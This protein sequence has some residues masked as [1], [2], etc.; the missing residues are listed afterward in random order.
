[1]AK[2]IKRAGIVFFVL[3]LSLLLAVGAMCVTDVVEKNSNSI[4]NTNSQNN[5]LV[6]ENNESVGGEKG[7]LSLPSNSTSYEIPKSEYVFE[8][9]GTSAQMA[10][11]W[12]KATQKSL[13]TGKNVKVILM[14][15]W[16]A[17]ANSTYTTSFG[18]TNAFNVGRISVNVGVEITLDLNGNTI[19]RNLVKFKDDGS[20][21]S[22]QDA[23]KGNVIFVAGKL[24][25]M[26]SKY[27]AVAVSDL[28]NQYKGVENDLRRVFNNLEYGK[29]TGGAINESSVG[30]G[31]GIFT[32]GELN[33]YSGIIAQNYAYA[34]GAIGIVTDATCNIYGGM[35]FNNRAYANGGIGWEDGNLS[36]YGGI[37]SFNEDEVYYADTALNRQG[38]GIWY[39]N[40]SGK[41]SISNAIIVY[42]N[43]KSR[44]AGVIVTT[45]HS[46]TISSTDISYNTSGKYGAGIYILNTRFADM[47]NSTISYNNANSNAAGIFLNRDILANFDGLNIHH[48]VCTDG[49]GAVYSYS[50]INFKNT[51]IA[52]NQGT[53]IGGLQFTTNPAIGNVITLKGPG[54]QIYG[55]T[56]QDGAESDV[57]LDKGQF[58]SVYTSLSTSSL[59]S[60]IG[61]EL[62]ATYGDVPFTTGYSVT[63]NKTSAK[64]YFFANDSTKK[65]AEVNDEVSLTASTSTLSEIP[66]HWTS[67]SSSG[68]TT[69]YSLQVP[70]TGQN[71]KLTFGSN[72]TFKRNSTGENLKSFETK[73]AGSYAF[74]YA[75]SECANNVFTFT[76]LPKQVDLE[77]TTTLTFNGELQ[78]AIAKVKSGDLLGSDTCTVNVKGGA[79]N[80]GED[81]YSEATGLSNGNYKINPASKFGRFKIVAADLTID[82]A[83]DN[84]S[85]KYTGNNIIIGEKWYNLSATLLGQ[86][87]QKSLN[88]LFNIDYSK[89][90]AEFTK[91]GVTTSGA[92]NVG[93]Y[94][95]SV[96]EFDASSVFKGNSNYN[97][98]INYVNGGTLTI[99]MAEVIRASVE[100]GYSYL[101]LDENNKRTAYE[102]KGLVHG[103]NDSNVNEK[104]GVA[105]YIL[106]NIKPNT[107]VNSFVNNL[108]YDK[109]QIQ[110]YNSNRTLIYDKG[111][112]ASGIQEEL[113]NNRYELAVGTG[114]YI[115]YNVG[116]N[117]ET[118]Y[119]SVLGDINGDGRISASDVSYLRQIANDS[120]LY[121]TL[122]VEKKLASMVINK[123]S[124]TSADAE[125][126]RN[127]IDKLLT[128]NIF[129]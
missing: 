121:E 108:V 11:G 23:E 109:T 4:V 126:V 22:K 64:L 42:N 79:M 86:D 102:T 17:E 61:I 25:L 111:V 36:I 1:M 115:E 65:V 119:L 29:I 120:T 9:S 58:I 113:L 76:I 124:V 78:T 81:Y 103:E 70:Y 128:I 107:A 39:T 91:D 35:I 47:I 50:S 48:N 87:S 117:V 122:S 5:I 97:V 75:E 44:G 45:S 62:S 14:N 116:G 16:V 26:D 24:N 3:V 101:L 100:S 56:T 123:G 118:I 57:Y 13:E 98:R 96:K 31:I 15:D 53:N 95:I 40:Y 83:T 106:G 77:W 8:L 10:D 127:I 63:N 104:E 84:V 33:F 19:N 34:S 80:V 54:V 37:I 114:W 69:E 94:E 105:R 49:V 67:G 85:K 90:I 93:I 6:N 30:G 60:K 72:L 73:N 125:I 55:N 66:W 129:F 92:V 74:Y 43:T 2:C 89:L 88:S 20:I 82:I 110:I 51:I 112:A 52:H 71:Y 41:L 38:G 59:I 68:S 7:E 46:V 99:S 28:Y 18:D 21:L 27:D 12:T 32:G